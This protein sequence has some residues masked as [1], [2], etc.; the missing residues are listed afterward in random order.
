M[1]GPE[2]LVLWRSLV[3]EAERHLSFRDADW[4]LPEAD[5]RKLLQ[6]AERFADE[7]PPEHHAR[8]FA[9][10][11][12]IPG[13]PRDHYQAQREAVDAARERA[14]AEVLDR[15][16]AEGLIRLAE[17]ADIPRAVGLAAAAHDVE[18]SDALLTLLGTEGAPGA[19]AAGWVAGELARHGAPRI[20]QVLEGQ[21]RD[22]ARVALLLELP[23]GD[24]TWELVERQGSEVEARYWG[25]ARPFGL[26]PE[27]LERATERLLRFD[28]PW[29]AVDLLA[30]AVFDGG[31]ADAELIER[32]LVQAGQSHDVDAA[33][34]AAW[35]VGQLLDALERA[36]LDPERLTGL[37]FTYFALVEDQRAPRALPAVLARDPLLFVRLARHAYSRED[38]AEEDDVRP[39]LAGHAWQVLH[40]LR[41]LPGQA[42]AAALTRRS[43]AS[44]S[45]RCAASS[46]RPA[47][48]ESPTSCSDRYRQPLRRAPT[49][50]GRPRRCGTSLRRS[51]PAASRRGSES[52]ASER[53]DR[54]CAIRTRAAPRN[55]HWPTAFATTLADSKPAGPGVRAYCVRSQRT[56]TPK[57]ATTTAT[58]S[59]LQT[60]VSAA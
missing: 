34:H 3:D 20:R 32:V 27:L 2:R 25:A 59:D 29:A 57:R 4:S 22:E 52:V 31:Q 47:A 21:V 14:T 39:E 23:P 19:L 56:T 44:G 12:R 13:I 9:H 54:P 26:A 53:V 35:E 33:V 41:R 17:A 28:R 46:P 6:A 49:A 38:G 10:R 1:G 18:I 24:E 40:G 50:V 16:G 8:L 30:G 7:D 43:C 55:A 45:I 42:T 5:A 15:H 51:A 48:P 11:A 37:E 58:P 36:R 60:T